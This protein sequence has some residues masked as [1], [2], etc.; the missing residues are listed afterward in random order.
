VSATSDI[1]A[2]SSVSALGT[3]P[4]ADGSVVG[5]AGNWLRYAS[6]DFGKGVNAIQMDLGAVGN[7]ANLRVQVRLDSASGKV[8]GT[9]TPPAAKKARRQNAQLA[10]VRKV[11]GVHD[12]FLVFV[13][14][15]G[16]VKV[17]SF[18]FVAPASKS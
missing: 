11:T 15:K 2:G 18:N 12:I 5:S 9:I 7:D 16:Q 13:G 8:I 17:K 3:Q 10:R 14:K 6:V 4:V 1:A